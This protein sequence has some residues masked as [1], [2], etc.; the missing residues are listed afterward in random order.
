MR[1]IFSWYLLTMTIGVGTRNHERTVHSI[2]HKAG[3]INNCHLYTCTP[4]QTSSW[5]VVLP[6]V[7]EQLDLV[8]RPLVAPTPILGQQDLV[9]LPLVAQTPVLEQQDLVLLTLVAPTPF[10]V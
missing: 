3:E 6:H 9:L 10:L 8:L 5:L 4:Y 7:P 2:I 1:N